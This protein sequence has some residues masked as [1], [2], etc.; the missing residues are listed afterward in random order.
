MSPE[1]DRTHIGAE[2]VARR[3]STAPEE[4]DSAQQR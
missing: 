4:N 1:G 3:A 2:F